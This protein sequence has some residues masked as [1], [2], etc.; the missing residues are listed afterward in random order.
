MDLN[1]LYANHQ[2][3]L[4]NARR[5]EGREDRQTYFDLVEYYAKRIGQYRHDASLPRY[6]W[7]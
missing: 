5:S 3:A 1:Q 2:R 7:K 4:V 6:H